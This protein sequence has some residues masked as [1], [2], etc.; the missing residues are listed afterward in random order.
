MT[1]MGGDGLAAAT[2]S[3]ILAA[4]YI[5]QRLDGALS[6][7][8]TR[9]RGGLVAHECIL[10]LRPLKATSGIAVEDVAKRLMDYGFHAPTMSFPVAGT[11]M[12]EPTESESK[13]ELDRF[14]DAMIAIRDE[15]R[16]IEAGR[17]DRD[18]N[19]LKNAPHT[20]AAV[21]RA[22]TGAHSL[23]ARAGRLS[24]RVVAEARSTGRRS[25]AS[26]TST[27]TAT[28]SAA[29]S[30]WRV[31]GRAGQKAAHARSDGRLGSTMRVLVLGAGVVGVTAAWYLAQDGHEVT[32]VD[33]QRGA[34]ARDFV[35]E[36]RPDLG[37]ARRAV[38]ESRRAAQDPAGGWGAR[39]RRCSSAC[40]PIRTSGAGACVPARVPAVA[41]APQH[42]PVPQPRALFAR[43][44]QVAARAKRESQYDQQERGILEFYTDAREYD[45]ACEGGSADARDRLRSRRR[46]PSTNASR[47]NR[48]S[49]RAATRLAGGIYTAHR[50][51]GRCAALHAGRWRARGRARRHVSL[52]SMTVGVAR[53]G[54]RAITGV[55]CR[56]RCEHRRRR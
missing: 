9:G 7:C 40:G 19:P 22:T 35:R 13:A 36:R 41:H 54:R 5:A 18:D 23:R 3:A 34:G 50:R 27:A 49:P 48:R 33:R 8:S 55:R 12:V 51:V 38:G 2:E 53:G 25:R 6:R 20:A 26:T 32:V 16:A 14:V 42:D 46:R 21:S 10:D 47:S 11:L 31:R 4:N 45:E 52:W 15:I 44:P 17:A 1:M 30:R 29:A 43:L 39:M 56:R 37:V 28:S 24:A